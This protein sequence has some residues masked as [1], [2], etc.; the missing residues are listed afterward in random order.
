MLHFCNFFYCATSQIPVHLFKM[1]ASKLA[2]LPTALLMIVLTLPVFAAERDCDKSVGRKKSPVEKK[3]TSV[4]EDTSTTPKK[5]ISLPKEDLVYLAQKEGIDPFNFFQEGMDPENEN[6]LSVSNKEG[7]EV[8]V[9]GSHFKSGP[10]GA[11]KIKVTALEYSETVQR[12]FIDYQVGG[13]SV[14]QFIINVDSAAEIAHVLMQVKKEKQKVWSGWDLAV[15]YAASER[16]IAKPSPAVPEARPALH[17]EKF[18]GLMVED[19]DTNKKVLLKLDVDDTGPVL[20]AFDGGHE[21]GGVRGWVSIDESVRAAIAKGE[22]ELLPDLKITDSANNSELEFSID[23]QDAR[24]NKR[25]GIRGTLN[26]K[27]I[28]LSDGTPWTSPKAFTN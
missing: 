6:E 5:G 19:R 1:K 4:L 24:G 26:G 7:L 21:L 15:I 14:Y 23:G 3:T 28:H 10:D 9:G 17:P 20:Y 8:S 13:G 16:A 27:A 18:E 22:L 11:N 12:Y 2:I 25:I